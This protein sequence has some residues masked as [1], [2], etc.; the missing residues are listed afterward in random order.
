MY[1][2]VLN[3]RSPTSTLHLRHIIKWD[4]GFSLDDFWTWYYA[5]YF[6]LQGDDCRVFDTMDAVYNFLRNHDLE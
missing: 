2:V 5:S 3:R 6:A 1:I 4:Y